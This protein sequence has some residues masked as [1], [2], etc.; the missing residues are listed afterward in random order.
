MAN[1]SIVII[2]GGPAGLE[3]AKGIADIGYKAIL[4]QKRD[5]LGG[6]PDASDCVRESTMQ[7]RPPGP[8]PTAP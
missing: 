8:S 6:M 2:G 5:K 7:G 1:E 3:A 4:V